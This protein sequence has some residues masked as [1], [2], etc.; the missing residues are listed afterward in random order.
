MQLNESR[1]RAGLAECAATLAQPER[2][3]GL[4]A[5][6]TRL[7]YRRTVLGPWS[8]TLSTCLMIA[9]V[10]VVYSGIFGNAL[11][12]YLPFF[13]AGTVLWTFIGGALTES[14]NVFVH[15]GG[16]I[17]S[18]PTPLA[19][20]IYRMLARHL[21]VLAH[22]AVVIAALWL[23][24]R[25]PVGAELLLVL[26]GLALVIVG[27]AGAMTAIGIVCT[28]FRDMPQLITSL[29]QLAFLLTPIIWP[30]ESVRG[31]AAAI[32]MHANP[33]YYFIEIVRAPLLGKPA[34]PFDWL[35]AALFASV[36]VLLGLALYSRFRGRIAYWL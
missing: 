35:M 22:N 25:W 21:I 12:T 23:Y 3:A 19:L 11:P 10:G 1:F 29:L 27:L 18:V 32:V 20:H 17:K 5:Y 16:L 13:A 14:C 33:L 6:D 24:F 36:T 4:A 28:R 2:W 9:S 34:E 7:R 15:A 30:P 31:K 8:T 26:P